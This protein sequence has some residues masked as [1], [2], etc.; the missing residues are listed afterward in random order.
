VSAPIKR[1]LT[2]A[3]DANQPLPNGHVL[4]AKWDRMI[5]A[6]AMLQGLALGALCVALMI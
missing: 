2:A 4:Q 3:A 5:G 6:R 1:Q